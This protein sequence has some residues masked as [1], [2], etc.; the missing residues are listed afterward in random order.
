VIVPEAITV[1]ELANR[2]AEKG[3][4]LVKA[5]FKL[6]MMVTVNQT[7]DQ[8][9]AELL[10][11]EFGHNIQR[12]SES[13]VDIDTTED[14]D[15]RNAEA[16]SAGRGDH[17]PR[18]PRQDQPA[19]CPARHRCGAGEAGGITQHIGAYQIKTKGGD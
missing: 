11:E 2:M 1:Q 9:T 17:G 4:D 6:G 19:R 18:R 15:A 8:D 3:A 14:V 7:I 16:P 5:L 10:V 12:V 13:D